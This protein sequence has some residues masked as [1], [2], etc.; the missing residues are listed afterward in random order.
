MRYVFVYE[1]G[2]YDS[3]ISMDDV[4][5]AFKNFVAQTGVPPCEFLSLSAAT[6]K[7]RKLQKEL[8]EGTV[9]LFSVSFI[10]D[11]TS[12]KNYE[13][14]KAVDALF[15]HHKTMVNSLK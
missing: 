3:S 12:L 8:D 14:M 13:H 4:K 15:D 2:K 7:R 5:H 11:S 6:V 10:Y 9:N 1:D